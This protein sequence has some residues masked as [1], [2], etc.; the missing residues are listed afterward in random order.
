M[1]VEARMADEANGAAMVVNVGCGEV[2]NVGIVV[3]VGAV[4]VAV[5][6]CAVRTCVPYC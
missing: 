4:A 6:L 1:V 5:K 3:I 2:V